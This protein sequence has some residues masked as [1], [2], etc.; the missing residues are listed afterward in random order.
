MKWLKN[1]LPAR[2]GTRPDLRR[3]HL[4]IFH[5]YAPP[6]GG[7]GHQFMHALET[8]LERTG[9]TIENNLLSAE[10]PACLFNSFNF[11]FTLLRR[12]RHRRCRMVHRVDG[13]IAVYRGVDDGTDARIQ[14][15]NQELA[16]AT[17][18]QS[19]YSL[20]KHQELGLAFKAPV[21]IPNAPDPALFSRDGR[22]PFSTDRKIRLIS[23]SWSDNLNKGAPV[24]Q[25]L[26]EHL[27]W[28]RYEYTF[29]GRSPIRFR[30]IRMLEPCDSAGIAAELRRHDL[31]L[32]ASRNDPCSNSLIEALACGCPALHLES[33]GHPELVARGGLG[34]REASEIPGKLEQLVE[35]YAS[36]Q[37]AIVLPSIAEI[38]RQ[39]RSV[40]GLG[41]APGRP[42][43][44]S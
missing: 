20:R 37:E 34:F 11:D 43:A 16:D 21:V 19:Q 10:T 15:I 36:F 3:D 23:V 26:D 24:Y 44:G 8:E 29:I 1:L 12:Q 6:P 2:P 22:L 31:Y 40:L 4:S 17:I 35:H 18:F 25:W 27:D 33:G 32:T 41:E 13:P 38:A 30:N 9:L 42:A 7:G 14:A 28:S 5:L 39:Y